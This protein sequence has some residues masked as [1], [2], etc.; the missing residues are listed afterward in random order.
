[1]WA[2]PTSVGLNDQQSTN[3]DFVVGTSGTTYAKNFQAVNFTETSDISVKENVVDLSD[4]L[5][6][7]NQLR[8]VCYNRIGETDNECG[9]IAQEV[10]QIMAMAVK[11]NPDDDLKSIAYTRIIPDL[12]GSIKELTQRIEQLEDNQ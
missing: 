12:I 11:N 3:G 2:G 6:R 10:E 5:A 4:S 7:V 9:L 8:P 1:M